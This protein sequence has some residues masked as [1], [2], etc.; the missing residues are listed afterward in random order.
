MEE[1]ILTEC[2]Q[3]EALEKVARVMILLAQSAKH[4]ATNTKNQ[5]EN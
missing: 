2:E 3:E 1:K 4:E 5:V